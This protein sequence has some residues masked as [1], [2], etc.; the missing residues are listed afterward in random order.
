MTAAAESPSNGGRPVDISYNSAPRAQISSAGVGL[1]TLDLFGRHVVHRPGDGAGGRHGRL[2]GQSR[3]SRH[4]NGPGRIADLRESEVEQPRSGFGQHHVSG[5]E[6][7][8]RQAPMVGLVDGICQ[9][10]S[11]GQH[12]RQRQRIFRPGEASGERLA[13]A[14]CITR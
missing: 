6:V 10:A 12:L 8:V 1:P 14:Y 7:P 2:R 5:L 4:R 13:F 11:D 9:L 3:H